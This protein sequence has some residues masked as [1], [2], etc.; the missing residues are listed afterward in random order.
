MARRSAGHPA[1]AASVSKVY[2]VYLMASQRNG[3][4]YIGVTND[5][6]RRTWEHREGLVPGFTKKYGVKI[7]VYYEE[8]GDI[9]TA[10]QR[11]TRLK[12]YKREWKL[13][14]IEA[15]NPD[16]RDLAEDLV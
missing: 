8:C 13:N 7:L 1:E 3:T 16:W 11:E 14:L 2:Y 5:L 6:V 4:L 9:G 12:K 15:R 10:I